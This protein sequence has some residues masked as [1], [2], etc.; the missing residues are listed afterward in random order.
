MFPLSL[1]RLLRSPG[2]LYRSR[3]SRALT[4]PS[5]PPQQ[6]TEHGP[7]IFNSLTKSKTPL[8]DTS[9]EPLKWYSCG[10]T[11]Y[12]S[13][14]LGH[15]R[16][17]VA[18]DVI[19]RVLADY[20]GYNIHYVM[21]VTDID[22]KIIGRT[23]EQYFLEKFSSTHTRLSSDL[24]SEIEIL[25]KQFLS[26][27]I[28]DLLHRNSGGPQAGPLCW[29]ALLEALQE[30]GRSEAALRANESLK[31][32]VSFA[33]R[34][35]EALV[36]AQSILELGEPAAARDGVAQLILQSKEVLGP[37]LNAKFHDESIDPD[38][39]GRTADF[40]EAQFFHDMAR[41]N[42]LPPD[43]VTR[44]SEYGY[45]YVSNGSVYFDTAKFSASGVHQ[46]NKLVAGAIGTQQ[47]SQDTTFRGDKKSAAD[48]ALWKAAKPGEP[49]WAS[50]WGP[51]RPG[52]HIECSAMASSIFGANIHIHSGGVD[53]M[54]PHHTNELAQSE[55]FHNCSD[56][57][58][59]FIH[60]GHLHI[61]GYKMS[62][63]LK[64]FI[65]I[66]DLLKRYTARQIRLAFLLRPWDSNLDYSDV[67]MTQEVLPLEASLNNFFSL[68]SSSSRNDATFKHGCTFG[69]S[70]RHL[71]EKFDNTKVTFHKA[72]CDSINT[73]ASIAA[74]RSLV[75]QTNTYLN[76]SSGS[77]D[78]FLVLG[79]SRWIM[80]M[81]RIFGLDALD[82]TRVGWSIQPSGSDEI[83]VKP[84]LPPY[85]QALSSFRDDIRKIARDKS[86]SMGRD[87]LTLCDRMRDTVLPPMGVQ[88]ADQPG[89]PTVIKFV[90]RSR[91]RGPNPTQLPTR[92]S[93][94]SS[95]RLERSKINPSDMFK[96]PHVTGQ[97]GSWDEQ[98][99]PLT[100]AD[101]MDLSKNRRKKLQK[102]WKFQQALHEQFENFH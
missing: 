3:F 26:S 63:S 67:I 5:N 81:L 95:K 2:Y 100:D 44:A 34:C 24:L 84:E 8:P 31:G 89:R 29:S 39:F 41:L 92:E 22:D 30:T 25:L 47:N 1:S 97:Y 19:R 88:L 64:N 45:G 87:I 46:Y 36:T 61:D 57:V 10:P 71:K 7:R 12:D 56:W 77:I 68:V 65:T 73:P 32:N 13:S 72:L 14:H 76:Q 83:T 49:S 17:Y 60:V 4:T 16:N 85:L 55:A 91:G 15:A 37:M 86:P 80:R 50:P 21:N 23:R 79:I 69:A 9:G 6:N 54:F 94:Q 42:V 90:E 51:G 98:G 78:S 35:L 20:F 58:D 102:Q 75:S 28:P 18:Q 93:T 43:T 74:I 52:W 38:L 66:E 53:L 27:R 96:P 99:V 48:F 59:C 101:G 70:E 62:K 11:V 33:T 82:A 40:W